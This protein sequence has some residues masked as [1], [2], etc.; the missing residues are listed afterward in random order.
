MQSTAA[1]RRFWI[2]FVT[3]LVAGAS[4]SLVR[5][6]DAPEVPPKTGKSETIKLFNGKDLTAGMAIRTCGR[7][8]MA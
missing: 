3:C 1:V 5:A 7:S 8:R 2:L 6:A 4:S